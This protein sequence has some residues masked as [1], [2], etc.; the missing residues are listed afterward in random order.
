MG[1]PTTQPGEETGSTPGLV[2]AFENADTAM[3]LSKAEK[4]AQYIQRPWW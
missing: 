4:S 3:N 2:F 1:E